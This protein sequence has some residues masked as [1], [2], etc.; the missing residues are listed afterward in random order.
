MYQVC[1]EVADNVGLRFKD[2][3]EAAYMILYLMACLLN[4]ALDFV[5]TYFMALQISSELGFHTYGGV[6]LKDIRSFTHQFE[7]Y[8]VQ[9]VMA[10]N[11]F[12]YAFPSTFLIPFLLEPV[13]TI[14]APLM[15]AEWVVRSHPEIMGHCAH[16]LLCN[17]PME[18]GRYADILLN[19]LLGIL[20]LYF[21]GGNTHI[22]FIGL[23]VSHV[24]IYC[25]DHYKVLRV[26]PNCQ[27]SSMDV[28]W[29]CQAMCAPVTGLLLSVLAFKA[30]C[31]GYGYCLHGLPLVLACGAA[32]VVHATVHMLL[33]IY[34][35]PLLGK[36]R[37]EDHMSEVT[38][39]H[40]ARSLAC[41]WF[42]AN[43]INCLRSQFFYEHKPYCRYCFAGKEHLLDE[44]HEIGCFF[45]DEAAEA[46]DFGLERLQSAAGSVRKM[47]RVTRVLSPTKQSAQS[48]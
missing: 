25:F 46:E 12:S 8:A 13:V 2:S 19:V 22:L 35:V 43:P 45:K 47:Q 23:C 5:T 16:M 15:L 10:E 34:V 36:I 40:V 28:D 20:F 48:A 44:N 14:V 41:S 29:W 27:F 42:N 31:Q 26:I 24:W 3:R 21:P 30:N 18:L 4:V 6:K 33:L 1:A 17:S 11:A 39:A 32:F 37:P 9:R 38:Y 7:S